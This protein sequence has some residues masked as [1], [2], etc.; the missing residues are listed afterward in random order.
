[1]EVTGHL[2]ALTALPPREIPNI[3]EDEAGVD[4]IARLDVLQTE[5]FLTM[6]GFEPRTCKSETCSHLKQFKESVF[7]HHYR[8]KC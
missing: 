6:S 3:L 2:H 1:M 4:A 7:E 5:N 8:I